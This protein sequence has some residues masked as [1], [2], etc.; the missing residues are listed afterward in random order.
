MKADIEVAG[1]EKIILPL[2][3]LKRTE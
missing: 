2:A 1:S 3:S